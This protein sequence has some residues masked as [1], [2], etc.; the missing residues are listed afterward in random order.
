MQT[1]LFDAVSIVTARP[2]FSL[3][4][5]NLPSTSR[6]FA[7]SI[8]DVMHLPS[9]DDLRVTTLGPCEFDSPL[10]HFDQNEGICPRFVGDDDTILLDDSVKSL[11]V[12][13]A[14]EPLA[15]EQAGPRR[16][17]YFHPD[18]AVCAIVTCGGLC[19]GLNNVIRAVVM[20]A[21]Y[22]Y[23]V[24]RIFG[25]RYG[26]EGLIEDYEHEV[27]SL[28]PE[29]VSPLHQFGG[30]FLGTSRGPQNVPKMV[31]RLV[32]LGVNI[33]FVVGGD[34]SQRGA[35]EIAA[36]A[37]RRG[38]KLAVIGIPKT[39]DN[40][41]MFMDKSFGYETAF[42]AAVEAVHAAHSEAKGSRNGVGL[43]KL[44]GRDS[45]FIACSTALATGDVNY[46]LIPEIPFQ[47]EGDH[48][49]LA[50]LR[51]RLAK[52]EHAV[53]IVA[54]GAGQDLIKAEAS[55]TDAS[56]NTKLQD[57]GIFLRQQI[58]KDFKAR[59]IHLNLKYIDP[60]YMIRSVPASPDDS[61]LCIQL[62]RHAVHAAMAG[63]TGVVV[64]R[65]RGHFVHLPIKAATS[66]RKKV[67]A[68]GDL[69][70]SVLE[71]TGQ[72]VKFG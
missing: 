33:L 24:R 26:Y 58:E 70:L 68:D 32:Q 51:R 40:D 43:V 66:A 20:Q 41:L 35:Y 44:M 53:V 3:L 5:L 18:G 4:C 34:G 59:N 72:P 17:I 6:R 69:W 7:V 22:R 61:V 19:P 47:L 2:L 38:R 71:T 9:P 42:T 27:I 30:T 46:V 65:M 13:G 67:E 37:E 23:K 52:R 11:K 21:R 55:G 54:E 28:N 62:A 64:G 56:G 1:E 39:I 16:K 31:D 15:V 10:L 60:S 12:G 48:G 57:I 49:L 14:K 29:L 50:V 25:F 36:E 63:K 8:P 45:G